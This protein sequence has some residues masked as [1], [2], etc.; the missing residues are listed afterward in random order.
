MNRRDLFRLAKNSAAAFLVGK[1]GAPKPKPQ[2]PVGQWYYIPSPQDHT[3]TALAV[4]RP[5]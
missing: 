1:Y 5:T 3:R 4:R 2:P